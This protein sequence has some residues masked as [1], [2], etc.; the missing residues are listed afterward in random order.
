MAQK[1]MVV[2]VAIHAPD[3]KNDERNFHV[4]MLLTMR[5][6]TPEGFGN[7][8]RA[9]NKD[10]ELL[11]WREKWSELGA[12][13]LERAGFALE[14][15]R[16]RVGHL[17]LQRQREAAVQRGDHE[18]AEA[19]DRTPGKHMGPHASAM[20]KQGIPTEKG[21]I[22]REIKERNDARAKER[23]LTRTAGEIRLAYQ[24]TD[25]AQAFADAL[26]D[27]GLILARV[28]RDDQTKLIAID[29]KRFEEK[30]EEHNRKLAYLARRVAE[31][32]ERDP[33][34]SAELRRRRVELGKQYQDSLPWFMRT[35]GAG[36]LSKDQREA[37]QL[38]YDNW[39][40]KL[41]KRHSFED[42]VVYVQDQWKQNPWTQSRF[43]GAELVVVDRDGEVYSL[44]ARNTGE[45]PKKLRKYIREIETAPLFN[46]RGAWEVLKA[47]HD[48]RREEALWPERE[49]AWPIYPPEPRLVR[50]STPDLFERAGESVTRDPRRLEDPAEINKPHSLRFQE[51]PVRARIW[52]AYN[53][54]RQAPGTFVEALDDAGILLCR[55][56]KSEADRSYRNATFSRAVNHYSP[57]YREGEIV[58]MAPD[59]RIYKIDDRNTD[60]DPKDIERFLKRLDRR[61]LPGI[62]E[63]TKIMHQ[64]AE[65]Q[66]A[67]AEL[68]KRLFPI[69]Q[70]EYEQ[71][72]GVEIQILTH[73][74]RYAVSKGQDLGEDTARTGGKVLR[75]SFG[76]LEALFATRL[77]PEQRRDAEIAEFE[78]RKRAEQQAQQQLRTSDRER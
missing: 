18:W 45:D 70:R 72:L 10:T 48:H 5:E 59:G 49:K 43:S 8:V 33:A 11:A 46:V 39:S 16:F 47:V 60:A 71:S 29:K 19:L 32:A 56:T 3:A 7:K 9:W 54:H 44:T 42:F 4:H 77:T 58:A 31:E 13:H 30:E 69:K 17:T 64:R 2:D 61:P 73:R 20:E 75:F 28:D 62:E 55:V 35:G 63:G 27:R 24:L 52:E 26:E 37:A 78:R 74:I 76:V 66:Q 22:N 41:K 40:A 12:N 50:T 36:A 65:A 6:L 57:R 1:G 34:K 68:M 25:R 38:R 15:D 23:S 21:E 67:T 14:A 53:R 51:Q